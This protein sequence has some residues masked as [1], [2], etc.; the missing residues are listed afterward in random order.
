MVMQRQL[1]Q[2]SLSLG[3]QRQQD[4]STILLALLAAH[5]ASCR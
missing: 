1:G 4:F 2:D 3:G 5:E